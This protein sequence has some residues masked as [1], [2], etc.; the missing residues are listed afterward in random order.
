MCVGG[1]TGVG[2][3]LIPILQTDTEQEKAS[4][5][6]ALRQQHNGSAPGMQCG[7]RSP[8]SNSVGPGVGSAFDPRKTLE[9]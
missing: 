6:S 5:N 1:G 7:E 9:M 2:E 4:F 3:A 8:A